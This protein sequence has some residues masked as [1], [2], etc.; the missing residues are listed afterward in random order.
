MG[1]CGVKVQHF[2]LTLLVVLTT[3]TLPCERD[4]GFRITRR[5]FTLFVFT[6]HRRDILRLPFTR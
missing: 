1:G 6:T 4:G 2:P 3:L 5:L